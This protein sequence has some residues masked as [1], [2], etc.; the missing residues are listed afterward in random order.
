MDFHTL[1]RRDLQALC[2]KNKIPANMTNVA[3][4]E[5]LQSLQTVEGL[6]E[7][8]AHPATDSLQTPAKSLAASNRQRTVKKEPETSKMTRTQRGTRKAGEETA[9]S[10]LKKAESSTVQ[11]A[12]STRR[13]TRLLEKQM[14]QLSLKEN[15]A[16]LE[17][18]SQDM[19]RQFSADMENSLALNN[20]TSGAGA[21][22]SALSA[23]M[24]ENENTSTELPTQ[25][26][27]DN[28]QNAV[29]ALSTITVDEHV[30][31]S[32]DTGIEEIGSSD[33]PS[34]NVTEVDDVDQISE[35]ELS[36]SEFDFLSDSESSDSRG[37][38]E[39]DQISE[40]ALDGENSFDS[41]KFSESRAAEV[42]EV[43]SCKKSENQEKFPLGGL[44]DENMSVV[45]TATPVEKKSLRQ[46][47]KIFKEKKQAL[48]V[49]QENV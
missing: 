42:N 48:Q 12:Y 4:A 30:F 23:L 37:E 8:L 24:T 28:A 33:I 39:V 34:H 41:N 7:V 17:Q 32:E 38:E 29:A 25:E 44:Q 26:G 21:A 3:M 18:D 19:Q 46:L 49:H 40:P 14:G 31:G 43:S 10:T 45:G 5:A 22:Q 11:Q 13:S 2:K 36:E 16:I 27:V 6:E 20:E 47:K 1:S 15:E 9:Q 35:I